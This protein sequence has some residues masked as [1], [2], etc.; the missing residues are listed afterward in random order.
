MW[1]GGQRCGF[2]RSRLFSGST[3]IIRSGTRRASPPAP[4]TTR[5]GRQNGR[6]GDRPVSLVG[7]LQAELLDLVVPQ[8]R[9]AGKRI[10]IVVSLASDAASSASET[11]GAIADSK[12]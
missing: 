3:P 11:R 4:S 9:A 1:I 8:C 12:E 6:D 5:V 7:D 2:F 10:A